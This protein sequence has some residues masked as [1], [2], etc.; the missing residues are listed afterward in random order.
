M[1]C[2]GSGSLLHR[3]PPFDRKVYTNIRFFGDKSTTI[4]SSGRGGLSGKM[5]VFGRR[6]GHNAESSIPAAKKTCKLYAAGTTKRI[7]EKTSFC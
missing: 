5:N 4:S 2:G 6:M 1:H 3:A 7:N